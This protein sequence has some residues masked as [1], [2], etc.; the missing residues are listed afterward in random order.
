MSLSP[1][2]VVLLL[3]VTMTACSGGAGSA[4]HEATAKSENRNDEN[5]DGLF[6]SPGD[7]TM[8][9]AGID[10][11]ALHSWHLKNIGQK[12]FSECSNCYGRAVAGEDSGLGLSHDFYNQGAGV[13]V[14]ISDNGT[15]I[16]HEDLFHNID[17]N[18]MRN[19]TS[20]DPSTW[21]GNPSPGTKGEVAAHGTAVAGIVGSLKD[22]SRGT[23]GIA[24]EA[25]LIP[26]KFV[27]VKG[28]WAK[29][30]DQANGL[31]DVFNYSYGRNSCAYRSLDQAYIDQLRYGV[32]HLRG[33][34]GA[35]YVKAAGNEYRSTLSDC[36]DSDSSNDGDYYYGN[37]SFEEDNSYPFTVVVGALNA[38]G[39]SSSYSSPG[40]VIWLSAPAGEYGVN[41]P[42]IL[43]TDLTGCDYGFSHD[44]SGYN[45]FE[46]G[47]PA[48]DLNND[49]AYTST[50]NGTSAATPMVSGAIALILAENPDLSWRDVKDILARS[51]RQV[52][53]TNSSVTHNDEAS[54]PTPAGHTYLK[55][56]ITNAAGFE[57]H[58]W[59][60]FGALNISRALEL[61][62]S[63][64]ETLP[65]L[66]ETVAAG[67][68]KYTRAPT[69]NIPDNSASGVTDK[70]N[71]TDNLVIEAI[72][73]RVSVD[74]TRASDLGVEI[75]SPS[76]TTSQ[77]MLINSNILDKK[78]DDII[79]LSNAFYGEDS[80]G[81]WTL[82][83]L[84]GKSGRT[85][86]LATWGVNVFGHSKTAIPIALSNLRNGSVSRNELAQIRPT[87]VIAG[88]ELANENQFAVVAGSSPIVKR[89]ASRAPA[90][91][92]I[93][94]GLSVTYQQNMKSLVKKDEK[95]K[96]LETQYPLADACLVGSQSALNLVLGEFKVP[97]MGEKRDIVLFGM[98]ET[99]QKL[100]VMTKDHDGVLTKVHVY[101]QSLK[102]I[103]EAFLED[104]KW[105][106]A[107]SVGIHEGNQIPFLT[108]EGVTGLDL[109]ELKTVKLL[110]LKN[111]TKLSLKKNES[112][113]YGLTESYKL[114][115]FNVLLAREKLEPSLDEK[116]PHWKNEVLCLAKEKNP[117]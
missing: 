38:S 1:S 72:Q 31:I 93:D 86:I 33:N 108:A 57:F 30:I 50:M 40:S 83:V 7:G 42:A 115:G 71:V 116:W 27:G 111:A 5:G 109:T 22:N 96:G 64:T 28:S 114:D 107:L 2:F 88:E 36:T 104:L 69:K 70:I 102:L 39:V 90:L 60:G 77:L 49:C 19:Y 63:T 91:P 24:P 65:Q 14:A 15:E 44:A 74:H 117:L 11:L 94:R 23:F 103:D 6:E 43:S 53:R 95:E 82:K 32:T 59:Y 92:S 47:K 10:P 78:L 55:G 16:M 56:W 66:Y 105:S 99:L 85:G 73:V 81:E 76:G 12:T 37:A 112:I 87:S 25:T 34:K 80:K 9:T 48:L 110:D 17:Q 84:D 3:L 52:D 13:R 26:F 100:V 51:A 54:Y 46:R 89:Q 113:V 29:E 45:D 21:L 61:A 62:R 68:W 35:L 97:L 98:S 106:D 58:N 18:S 4:G 79:L 41:S 101:D 67:G 8:G 20:E 75:T